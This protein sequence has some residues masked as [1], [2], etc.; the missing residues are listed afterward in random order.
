[1]FSIADRGLISRN[2]ISRTILNLINNDKIT[3][4]R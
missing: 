4:V 2:L 3:I 1:M